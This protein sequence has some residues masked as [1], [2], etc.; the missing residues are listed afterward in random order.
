[1]FDFIQRP[2]NWPDDITCHGASVPELATVLAFF[3]GLSHS[4]LGLLQ[5]GPIVSFISPSVVSGFIQAAAFTIPLGQLKKIF[6]VKVTGETFFTKIH[7]IVTHIF[8]GNANW[9]DFLIGMSS[10]VILVALK[11]LKAYS[12]K[13]D[14]LRESKI[15]WF[16][17]TAKA[18]IVTILMMVVAVMAE[19]PAKVD[20]YLNHNCLS[21]HR[22]PVNKNNCTTL[23]LTKIRNVKFPAF[24]SPPFHFNYEF[25]NYKEGQDWYYDSD[26]RYPP[27]FHRSTQNYTIKCKPHEEQD[28]WFIGF[29]DV[30]SAL[31][32]GLIIQPI[33]SYLELISLGKNFAKQDH[34]RVD[35]TQ[36][37]IALGLTNVMNS[38]VRLKGILTFCFR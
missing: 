3:L 15:I 17:C 33:I 6:G 27:G 24:K 28:I 34:A 26:P 4:I 2:D 12:A 31:G 1:M 29:S 21:G 32:G 35:P 23:T 11:K 8:D 9:Y 25:C 14:R 5:L 22:D 36:E 37:M 7:D 16:I 10:I 13:S 18:A 38:F 30:T 19:S 20:N